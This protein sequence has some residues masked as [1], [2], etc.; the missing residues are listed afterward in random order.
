MQVFD[1]I[2]QGIQ[3]CPGPHQ[4]TLRVAKAVPVPGNLW[5]H[6]FLHHRKTLRPRELWTTPSPLP[7]VPDR[8]VQETVA[9]GGREPFFLVTCDLQTSEWGARDCE[10][11]AQGTVFSPKAGLNVGQK[12][13]LPFLVPHWRSRP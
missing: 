12:E 5:S 2:C 4:V 7:Q 11:L 8:C 13:S 9:E 10:E 3:E 6:P 1:S